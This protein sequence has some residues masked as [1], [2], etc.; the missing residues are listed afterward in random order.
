MINHI[1]VSTVLRRTVCDLYSNLVTRPTGAAVRTEIELQLAAAGRRTL[2]VID[3]SNVN[4]LDFSCADEIVAKLL[5]R[6]GAKPAAGEG[7]ARGREP[8]LPHEGYFLFR[9]LHDAHL[10]A[11]EAV[12]ERHGLALVAEGA[13]GPLLV[14][15]VDEGERRAWEAMS[16]LGAAAAEDLARV[17]GQ[18]VRDA[19]ALLEAL[20]RR[21]LLMRLDESYVA[22][23]VVAGR[24]AVVRGGDGSEPGGSHD[25]AM[26]GEAR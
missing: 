22:V 12:L 25:G 16:R 23:A 11:I 21:R 20:C 19:E 14:G 2:T 7:D 3:F 15:A 5:L 9:G 8:V 13:A 6:Y 4:L 18:S 17:T 10:D 26:G 1:D 24:R